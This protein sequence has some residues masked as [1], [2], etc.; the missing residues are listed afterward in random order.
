MLK[1][2]VVAAGSDLP[3]GMYSKRSAYEGIKSGIEGAKPLVGVLG[4]GPQPPAA[5]ATSAAKGLHLPAAQATS[6]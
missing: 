4:A 5:Q 6:D 1:R 2:A 3:I